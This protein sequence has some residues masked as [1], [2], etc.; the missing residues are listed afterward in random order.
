MSYMSYMS[1]AQICRMQQSSQF[2]MPYSLLARRP[3]PNP[4]RYFKSKYDM[5][6]ECNDNAGTD[7]KAIP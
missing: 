1:Y 6:H 4:R 2:D 3:S 5:D 7:V